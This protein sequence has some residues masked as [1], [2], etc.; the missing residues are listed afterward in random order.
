MWGLVIFTPLMYGIPLI[1]PEVIAKWK[2]AIYGV[3]LIAVLALR[4]KGLIDK[5]LMRTLRIKIL[6]MMRYIKR[7]GGRK[8]ITN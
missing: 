6:M 3:I 7:I 5:S 4:P 8:N 1:L 2:Y